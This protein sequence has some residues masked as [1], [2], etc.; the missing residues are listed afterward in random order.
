MLVQETNPPLYNQLL[1][2][3]EPVLDQYLI[4]VHT[5]LQAD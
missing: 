2:L 5:R 1:P 3:T 4:A